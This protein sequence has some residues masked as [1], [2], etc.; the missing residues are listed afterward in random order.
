MGAFRHVAMLVVLAVAAA[1]SAGCRASPPEIEDIELDPRPHERVPLAAQITLRTNRPTT[2][3]LEFD[4]GEQLWTVDLRDPAAVQHIVPILG[5]RPDRTHRI[6]VIVTDERGGTTASEPFEV[7]T[8]PLPADF[9]PLDVRVSDRDRMEPGVTMLEPTYRSAADS[10]RD[11][12]WLVAVDEA[13]AVVWYY[14]AAQSASDARRLQNGHLLYRTG[15]AGPLYEIDMLGH[16]V[17]QWHTNRTPEDQVGHD[18]IHID[19]ETLHHETFE[20]VSGT[21]L[22]IS[23]EFRTYDNYPTS[24]TDPEAPRTPSEVLGDVLVEFSR[25][26]DVLRAVKLLDLID[27]YRIGYSSLDWGRGWSA[28]FPEEDTHPR[29]DWAHA[30]AVVMDDGER[31]VIA[32]LRHQDAVVKI[33]WDTGELVWILG[34]HADW[35]PEWQDYLLQPTGDLL[36]PYHQHAPMITPEGT[37]LMFDNGN[38][39]ARPFDDPTPPSESFSRAVEYDVDE[40]TMEVAEVWSYGGPGDEPFFARFLG[41]ADWLPQTGNVL[42]T[43]GGLVS[44]A[45]GRPSV[46]GER[47]NWVRIVEVTH[48]TPAQ[49]VFELFIDDER[50]A[51]W[52][53]YRAERLPSLYP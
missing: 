28:V 46:E 14:R 13:G 30:N 9:P 34:N 24:D 42:I 25:Q 31:Y 53:V 21:I 19:T 27:P 16:T 39:R 12:H 41:D 48:E 49:T 20:T 4:D 7:T 37:I 18:S 1:L 36:W 44:D 8:D 45:E 10:G 50:P 17:S 33:D 32:S 35:G 3:A 43:Y 38:N 11:E 40:D 52:S 26:G 23:T 29:R 22:G 47:H 2:V 15:R 5:M 51:G 6:R